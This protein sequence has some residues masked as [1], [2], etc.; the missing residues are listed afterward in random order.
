MSRLEERVKPVL[1][2]LSTGERTIPDLSYSEQTLL[3]RW[4]CKTAFVLHAAT[5]SRCVIP[6]QI[7][8][9]LHEKPR[10]CPPGVVVVAKQTPDLAD[11]IRAVT[12]LQSDRFLLIRK[13]EVHE[14]VPRWKISFRIGILQLLF[15]Y[16]SEPT[17]SFVGWRDVHAPLWPGSLPL[18]YTIR[19][20]PNLIKPREE[21]G[22]VL[23]HLSLGISTEVEQGDIDL[24]S[25]PPLEK[26][27]EEFFASID[28][29]TPV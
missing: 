11:D 16:C 4:T 19:L 27:V 1:L 13:A 23:F 5:Y 17:W 7:C 2:P 25:R 18:F 24:L 14:E 28:A 10:L 6:Q 20:R 26:E 3:L 29:N 22:T 8:P 15:A 21:A 12:A 9:L